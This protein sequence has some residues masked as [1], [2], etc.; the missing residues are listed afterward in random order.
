[1]KQTACLPL[2]GS[3]QAGVVPAGYPEGEYC[4]R[5]LASLA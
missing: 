4:S 1:M 3:R 2:H 5:Q